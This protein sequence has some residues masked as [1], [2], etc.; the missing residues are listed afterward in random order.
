ME[1]LSDEQRGA[2]HA[3]L[4]VLSVP[5]PEIPGETIQA[6][7]S[8]VIDFTKCTDGQWVQGAEHWEEFNRAT[9]EVAPL[10]AQLGL[11]DTPQT[12]AFWPTDSTMP[13][14]GPDFP[15]T[16]VLQTELDSM[17]PYEQ[18]HA[19]GTGLP[20]ASLIVVDNENAHGVFPYGTDE[21]DRPVINFLLGGD[22][23]VETIVAAGKPMP[24]EEVTYESWS[25][26]TESAQHEGDVPLFT[27]PTVP[28]RTAEQS[29][30]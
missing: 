13:E 22:R 11:L 14:A 24:M 27:D 28:A 15:E 19:A 29:T 17:T 25:P 12:C 4:A 10:S 7:Y 8:E 23:P 21:V 6:T 9:A 30:P 5:P 1:G 3:Q 16:I 2:A 20:N 18:G 26:L